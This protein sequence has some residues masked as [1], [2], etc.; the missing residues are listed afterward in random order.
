MRCLIKLSSPKILLIFALVLPPLLLAAGH[1]Y[2][3]PDN[4]VIENRNGRNFAQC[5][6]YVESFADTVALLPYGFCDFEFLGHSVFSVHFK[7]LVPIHAKIPE[8]PPKVSDISYPTCAVYRPVV[9]KS[10]ISISRNSSKVISKRINFGAP[11]FENFDFDDFNSYVE[12][13]DAVDAQY[14]R[15]MTRTLLKDAENHADTTRV[16]FR[17]PKLYKKP[18]GKNVSSDQ[19]TSPFFV[20]KDFHGGWPDNVYWPPKRGNDTTAT[21]KATK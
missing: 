7:A 9:S 2:S 10:E 1:E 12:S 5:E 19:L 4:A 6:V 8:L 3:P 13:I 21:K 20:P 18:L 14:I 17:V 16:K 15:D 11:D